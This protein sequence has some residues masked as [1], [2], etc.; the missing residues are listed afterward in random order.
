[1]VFIFRSFLLSIFFL[2]SISCLQAAPK[3][4]QELT[5]ACHRCHGP[6]GNSPG[7]QYPSL[8]RQNEEYLI[9]QLQ[10]FKSGARADAQMSPL[11]GVLSDEDIV[12]LANFYSGENIQRQRGIDEEQKKIGKD[13]AKNRACASCHQANYR[14]VGPI[15]R[16]SRQK[17]I[18]LVKSMKDFRDG[19]R[20]NDNGIKTEV[21]KTL[22][23][24]EIKALSHFL[25][26]M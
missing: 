22:S 6:D 19:K 18:Y 1:M 3:T 7:G 24:E 13:I 4:A 11:V 21:M 2:G 16:I 5:G 12:L 23:D 9:K 15:P 20:T 17:R 14:G 10:D 25:A 26:G 8:A